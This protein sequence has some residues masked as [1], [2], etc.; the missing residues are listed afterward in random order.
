M[1]EKAV[2]GMAVLRLLSGIT[3]LTAA[4]LML[5]FNQ[6]DKALVINAFLAIVGPLILISTMSI[7]LLG[8][9]ERVSIG[10]LIWIIA[11][12]GLILFGLKK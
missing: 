9:A 1:L 7:G 2:L 3:E 5:K 4:L 11:G 8:I 12:I 6:V 10:K